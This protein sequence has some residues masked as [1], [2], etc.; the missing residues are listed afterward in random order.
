MAIAAPQPEAACCARKSDAA[1]V[2]YRLHEIAPGQRIRIREKTASPA[3][4]PQLASG[5][6]VLVLNQQGLPAQGAEVEV[7]W[8]DNGYLRDSET[9]GADGRAT[10]DVPDGQHP[11]GASSRTDHFVV[12]RDHVTAPG[13]VT[14]DTQGTVSVDVIARQAN[15]QPLGDARIS[16][17]HYAAY[18]QIGETDPAGRARADLLP[19]SY[20]VAAA[21]WPNR[22][23]LSQ[24]GTV[25][26]G[27][28]T[29][30]LDPTQMGLAQI[31]VHELGATSATLLPDALCRSWSPAFD[32]AEGQSAWLSAGRWV[33][34]FYTQRQAGNAS[35]TYYLEAA[36]GAELQLVAGNVYTYTLGTSFTASLES[37]QPSY[38]PGAI[39]SL[40]PRVVD[41]S[42]NRLTQANRLPEGIVRAQL[43][44]TAP[45]GATLFSGNAWAGN[46][47]AI[48]LP[49]DAAPGV[50]DATFT[51]DTGPLQGILAASTQFTVGGAPL[52]T[53]TATKPPLKRL[54]LP[55]LLKGH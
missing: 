13:S 49:A 35:W 8:A 17:E 3:A 23:Y 53:P 27:P 50:Y 16:F 25:I 30:T 42:G 7:Y 34:E 32:L 6:Q 21:N 14:L 1:P 40:R 5:L 20:C 31:R 41:Q 29:V 26:N 11:I 12:W 45:G 33:L 38:A 10:L 43:L 54:Y 4:E 2:E 46:W 51:W 36:E 37:Y 19:G 24:P 15:G 44:V 22:L 52:P 39:V 9:T 55:L 47:K 48:K 28:T 18:N